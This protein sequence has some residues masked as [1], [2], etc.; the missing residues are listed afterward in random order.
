MKVQTK[1]K[2]KMMAKKI[3]IVDNEVVQLHEPVPQH[4]VWVIS[5]RNEELRNPLDGTL[6]QGLDD[7]VVLG[8][9]WADAAGG[10]L[11]LG[12]GE[13]AAHLGL[14]QLGE[15][16]SDGVDPVSI[17]IVD[18]GGSQRAGGQNW[19]VRPEAACAGP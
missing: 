13:P 8:E 4:G 6:R 15:L 1:A 17:I 14:P 18:R 5:W 10:K 19:R 11:G 12:L 2:L 9:W 16:D 7:V 3:D